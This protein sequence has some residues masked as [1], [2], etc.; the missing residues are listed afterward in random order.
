MKI[1][2]IPIGATFRYHGRDFTVT[3]FERGTSPTGSLV[4]CESD[5]GIFGI[6]E[7][8]FCGEIECEAVAATNPRAS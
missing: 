1:R 3:A 5:H 8:T 4:T 2:D 7:H 6:A